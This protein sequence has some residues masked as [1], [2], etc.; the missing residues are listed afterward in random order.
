MKNQRGLSLGGFIVVLFLLLMVAL[1]GFKLFT[2]YTEYFAIQK[3]LRKL[4]E[5]PA[6]KTWT[7]R[8]LNAAFQPHALIDRISAINAQDIEMGK[9][10]NDVVLS[11]NYSVK[12]PLFHNISLII[13][14]APTSK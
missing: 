7:Q 1:L 9:E 3:T 14:F 6:A 10:G 12:V 11:A 2:P 8:D 4:A 13:D 5:D